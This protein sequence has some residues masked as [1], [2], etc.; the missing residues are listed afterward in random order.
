MSLPETTSKGCRLIDASAGTG[1]TFRITEIVSDLVSV[2]DCG[3]GDILVVTFTEAATG[4]L[5]AR[6]RSRLLEDC[7]KSAGPGR[8]RLIGALRNIDEAA[9]STIHGFCRK[10][11]LE[12][13]FETGSL[14]ESNILIN[15]DDILQEVY[16]DFIRSHLIRMPAKELAL[17][18]AG[19]IS[20]IPN[21][22]L[23]KV[24]C[25]Y[26]ADPGLVIEPCFD[27]AACP[28]VEAFIDGM[29]NDGEPCGS[30]LPVLAESDMRNLAR[31]LVKRLLPYFAELAAHRKRRK[32]LITFNDMLIRLWE[33]VKGVSRQRLI[34]YLGEKYGAV[35]IDEFQDTDPIQYRIFRE[36][37]FKGSGTAAYLIGDPKQ[38]IYSFRGA[39]IFSY[40]A[41]KDSQSGSGLTV[42]AALEENWRSEKRLIDGFNFLFSSDRFFVLDGIDYPDARYPGAKKSGE[43]LSTGGGEDAPL[44]FVYLS[45]NGIREEHEY[46]LTGKSRNLIEAS[47]ARKRIATFIADEIRRLL[48]NGRI[49]SRPVRCSD[50]ALLVRTNR[51]ASLLKATLSASGIPAVIYSTDSVFNSMECGDLVLLLKSIMEPGNDNLVKQ[52]LMTPFFGKDYKWIDRASESS[53]MLDGYTDLLSGCLEGWKR[54]NFIT[55][56]TPLLYGGKGGRGIL[57]S[58]LELDDGERRATNL[59][60]CVEL[61]QQYAHRKKLSPDGIIRWLEK[62]MQNGGESSISSSDSV[63]LRLESDENAVKI[64]TIHRSKGLEFS[65]VFVPYLWGK[66]EI[67]RDGY[68]KHHR[69]SAGTGFDTCLFLKALDESRKNEPGKDQGE[70]EELAENMRL[71]YVAVTRARHKCFLFSG[72][73]YNTKLAAMKYLLENNRQLKSLLD[74]AKSSGSGRAADSTGAVECIVKSY[75][76]IPDKVKAEPYAGSVPALPPL[77]ADLP[78]GVKPERSYVIS[79][80]TGIMRQSRE[81]PAADY[82]DISAGAEAPG[83]GEDWSEHVL[84]TFPGGSRTGSFFHRVFERLDFQRRDIDALKNLVAESLGLFGFETDQAEPLASALESILGVPL[85]KDDQSFTLSSLSFSRCLRELS[86]HFPVKGVMAESLLKLFGSCDMKQWQKW[87]ER[88]SFDPVNGYITGAI[89]LIAEHGGKFYLIDWK[90]N[91]LGRNPEAYRNDMLAQVISRESYYLQYFLYAV[92]LHLY[93]QKR[94][95]DYKHAAHFGGVLYLFIRGLGAKPDGEH[96][97]FFVRPEQD[98]LDSFISEFVRG[99]RGGRP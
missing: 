30:A 24:A 69:K 89:D 96:G 59:M 67:G 91:L 66:V 78:A 7:R 65:I 44:S 60:H 11:L 55:M 54:R 45:A 9:I 38:S 80:F 49:G 93:L 29:L 26:L 64:L 33:A 70:K 17:L 36:L 75:S 86:F 77:I 97:I 5:R 25:S 62:Q 74:E 12:Q 46:V 37:F 16:Y 40:I 85:V 84:F 22:M 1:K 71:L 19:E 39:D 35:L 4:E 79:S 95:K 63:L 18:L 20:F 92:A 88:L 34:D 42:L 90:S 68:Y 47:Y 57:H 32:N 82:D 51:E 87:A 48:E 14:Y 53:G 2:K 58:L 50:F 31:A 98:S 3:I 83:D 21:G 81:A 23:Y 10:V 41:A 6:V 94:K 99:G 76:D 28:A 61:T 72:D 56:L 8:Q 13:A 73:L 27:N 43:S 15:T 52:L